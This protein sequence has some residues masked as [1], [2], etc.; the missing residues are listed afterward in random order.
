MLD[1]AQRSQ[2]TVINNF[3]KPWLSVCW[4]CTSFRCSK[5]CEGEGPLVP[6]FKTHLNHTS[7]FQEP[8]KSCVTLLVSR[9]TTSAVATSAL[10]WRCAL[11]PSPVGQC[12]STKISPLFPEGKDTH[13]LRQGPC[14]IRDHISTVTKSLVLH[15]TVISHDKIALK[16][17]CHVKWHSS[18]Q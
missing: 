6:P 5:N 7:L 17:Q 2:D 4:K 16:W 3:C 12:G 10:R 1:W 18:W 13:T 11:T 14:D 9:L 15:D 8:H